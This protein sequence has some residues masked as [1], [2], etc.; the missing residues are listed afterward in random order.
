M[1]PEYV[2]SYLHYCWLTCAPFVFYVI[3]ILC[4]GP[5]T[6]YGR[7]GDF[8]CSG[9]LEQLNFEECRSFAD[10]RGQPFSDEAE[11]IDDPSAEGQC[12]AIVGL[13]GCDAGR[14]IKVDDVSLV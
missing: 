14:E 11:C 5:S 10:K 4:I 1:Y 2:A 8:Y 12:A 7:Q 13:M 3:I 6:L 9:V